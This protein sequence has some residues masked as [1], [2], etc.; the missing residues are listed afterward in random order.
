MT[1]A[2]SQ[3]AKTGILNKPKIIL[4]NLRRNTLI[5]LRNAPNPL[6]SLVLQGFMPSQHLKIAKKR[7]CCEPKHTR[8]SLLSHRFEANIH[9]N[10]PFQ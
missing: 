5:P 8:M 10:G 2:N 1:K 6:N 9:Q 3:S 7:S 4:Q